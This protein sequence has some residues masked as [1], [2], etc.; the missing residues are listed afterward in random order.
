MRAGDQPAFCQSV[1]QPVVKRSLVFELE[2]GD[3]MGDLLQRVL[4]RMCIGVHRVDTPLVAGV[5]VR[6]SANPVQRRVTHVDV[7]AGHVNPGAED[8]GAV[9]QLAV[10]HL[11]EAHQVF[12]WATGAE[13][14]VGAKRVEVAARSAHFPGRLLV[15]VG[16]AGDNQVLG[17]PVHEIE[18][19]AREIFVGLQRAG[20]ARGA[21]QVCF[22]AEPLHRVTD[23]VN[24]FLLF[25]LWVGV[26]EA[27]VTHAAIFLRQFEVKPDTFG[28]ADVQ[29]AVGFRGKAHSY[30]GLVL[31]ALRMVLRIARAPAPFAPRIDALFEVVLDYVT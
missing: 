22:I 2:R 31:H 8:C 1:E 29:V 27:K 26:V 13:W 11:A 19:V 7:G 10:A 25:L 9:V 18:V 14:T 21:G 17:R 23:A 16:Q 3:R 20:R 30:P 4:D 24:V 6:G 5:V 15:H 12:V 28:M